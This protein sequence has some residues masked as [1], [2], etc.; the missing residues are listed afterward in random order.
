[1]K[2]ADVLILGA[3][4]AGTSLAHNLAVANFGGSVALIDARTDFST[5]QSWC[6]WGEIP[7][8]MQTLVRRRWH[9][10]QVRDEAKVV[11][12][13]SQTN[14]Y[15]QIAA[16][17][18]FQH[19]HLNW[20]DADSATRLFTG[21]TV[22]RIESRDNRVFV[23]TDRD[24]WQ[25]QTVFD[26][27]HRGSE[28]LKRIDNPTTNCL[29]QSFIGW[30]VEFDREVFDAETAIIMDFRVAERDAGI[31]FLY[32][33]PDSPTQA[34]VE[35]TS[36][37][38]NA[39]EQARHETVLKD[40]LAAH[41]GQK[42]RIVSREGGELPM[43]SAKFQF[44]SQPNV[45]AVGVAGGQARPSSGY[46]FGRIQKQTLQI[47]RA[48]V[49]ES[50]LKAEFS[51]PKYAFLDAVFLRIMRQNPV[52]A[53]KSFVTLFERV[54]PDVLIRFLA[55]TSSRRDDL[56]IISALPKIPFAAA[57]VQQIFNHHSP[58]ADG[59]RTHQIEPSDAVLRSVV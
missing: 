4:C 58:F 22:R 26:A 28:N 45:Y 37:A 24:E 14:C 30:N 11:E 34:L 44:Q 17:D 50:E 42:Y 35:S 46:A 27:R 59:F 8:E 33:L 54:A 48:V 39:L 51:H 7:P 15:Q 10:W 2:Y 19:F 21:E 49:A 1:M 6:S 52:L 31:H 18:F 23:T 5:A 13:G 20:R 25:A 47:A 29:K 57:A 43:T 53:Q 9:K 32:V 36:F 40:Y 16:A 3:G 56:E 12:R 38:A 55:E 41:F